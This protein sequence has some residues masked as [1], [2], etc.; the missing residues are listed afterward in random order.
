MEKLHVE[1]VRA[2]HSPGRGSST[3]LK[4]LRFK[5]VSWR[6]D[7]Q[8]C[9]VMVWDCLIVGLLWFHHLQSLA[10]VTMATIAIGKVGKLVLPST[11]CYYFF[12]ERSCYSQPTDMQK[13]LPLS[14]V[15][16]CLVLIVLKAPF[17]V[18]RQSTA[19]RS[20]V[21]YCKECVTQ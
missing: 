1:D 3:I 14:A 12:A 9:I 2:H 7:F 21:G 20:G 4:W 16:F 18:W 11:S 6:Y 10:N 15:C 19:R 8:P 17:R 5:G 13:D